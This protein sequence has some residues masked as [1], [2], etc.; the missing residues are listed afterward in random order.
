MTT[1]G[2]PFDALVA[3]PNRSAVLGEVHARPFHP[4]AAPRRLLHFGF[5]TDHAEARADR[6][7][8]GA[9]CER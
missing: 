5:L 3:H 8:L 6:E 9:Y 7:A 4:I 2:L 1:T